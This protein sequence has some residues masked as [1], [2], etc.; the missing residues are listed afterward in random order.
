MAL[1]FIKLYELLLEIFIVLFKLYGSAFGV[2]INGY[3]S[4][5]YNHYQKIQ[6]HR[7]FIYIYMIQDSNKKALF[8]GA[9]KSCGVISQLSWY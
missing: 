3:N 8:V 9:D 5:Y 6:I 2:F 1:Y 7:P 4:N